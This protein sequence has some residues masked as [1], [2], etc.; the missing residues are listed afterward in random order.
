MGENIIKKV[1]FLLKNG[2][3]YGHFKRALV[4]AEYLK[5]FNIQVIFMT[6]A[7][8]TTIF[9]NKGYQVFNFPTFHNLPNGNSV[10]VVL[11]LV[12]K[13]L[14]HIHPDLVI[15]DTYPDNDYL[16][17]PS[18]RYI[19]RILILRRLDALY[20]SSLLRTGIL[21][22][23]KK[24]FFLDTRD[25]VSKE[26]KM[27]LIKLFLKYASLFDFN[28]PV[29]YIPKLSEIDLL[30]SK[31][32]LSDENQLVVANCGAGGSHM[33]EAAP[34]KIFSKLIEIAETF[35]HEKKN[36]KF[37]IVIGPYASFKEEWKKVYSNI[38]I[39]KYEELLSSLLF[40]ADVSILRPGYNSTMEA[41]N[42]NGNVIL[43]PSISYLENQE[44]WCKKLKED[45][46]VD[47]VPL[48][49]LENLKSKIYR[50]L[51][52]KVQ[53]R[54]INNYNK[55][56]SRKINTLIRGYDNLRSNFVRK[57]FCVFR[58][59]DNKYEELFLKERQRTDSFLK[60]IKLYSNTKKS[61]IVDISSLKKMKVEINSDITFVMNQFLSPIDLMKLEIDHII[62]N[63]S[64]VQNYPKLK[65][66]SLH[67][68]LISYGIIP[69]VLEEI[70]P[71]RIIDSISELNY[72]SSKNECLNILFYFNKS[73]NIESMEKFLENLEYFVNNNNMILITKNEAI[74]GLIDHKLN[75]YKYEIDEHEIS[76][77]S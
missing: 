59:E 1:V 13:V 7:K 64:I 75:K 41:L 70:S 22:Q 52:K 58:F 4:L 5:D 66:Y 34:E 60:N 68:D 51:K 47:Y 8:N 25:N 21:N 31:Y 43:I 9:T 19:P 32:D 55:I 39:V 20:F 14:E 27:P 17:I 33:G 10:K 50:N 62:F 44:A 56:I 16:A 18:L 72:L 35:C 54:S 76:K 3:G 49:E 28:G 38:T 26:H 69:I 37:I 11:T 30:D 24:I 42:G 2:I 40:K 53:N 36:V 74:R 63:N 57:L 6:Q 71:L 77:L 61:E 23:Y 45:Y 48:S 29:F 67:Y 15:E 65:D 12:N 46:D 73:V